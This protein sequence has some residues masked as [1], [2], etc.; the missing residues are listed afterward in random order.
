[1][2]ACGSDQGRS[3]LAT[4]TVAA[5]RRGLPKRENAGLGRKMPF[6]DGTLFRKGWHTMTR[7]IILSLVAVLLISALFLANHYVPFQIEVVVVYLGIGFFVVGLLS[8]IKPFRFFNINSRKL[9]FLL[10]GASLLFL[11]TG[12]ILPSPMIRSSRPHQCI[13]DFMPEYQFYEYHEMSVNAPPGAVYKAVREVAF[14]DIPIA[15]WLLRI[16]GMTTGQFAQPVLEEL[17]QPG[18]GFLEL[19]NSNPNE[20]VGGMVGKPWSNDQPP[21]V[22]TP[23][24][25]RAFRLAGN[26]KVAFNMHVVA[27]EDGTSRLSS[28]TRII[29]ID[30]SAQKTFSRYWRVIYPG[31]AI[32]RRVW[33]DAIADRAIKQ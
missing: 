6:V 15:M 3:V 12:M 2:V 20:Y 1:M 28:E 22:K 33:L 30:E 14:T 19:E 24:E 17:M 10:A 27:M 23:D 4:A 11:V 9:A 13:D 29:G 18:T 21:D 26:I 32:I 5:L 25:F 31:S 7:I 8:M 16:R